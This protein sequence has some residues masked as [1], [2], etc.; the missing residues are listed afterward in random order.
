MSA[1]PKKRTVAQLRLLEKTINEIE[2]EHGNPP[3][4]NRTLADAIDVGQVDLFGGSEQYDALQRALAVLRFTHTSLTR[5]ERDGVSLNETELHGASIM[6]DLAT[7]ALE[8]LGE[9]ALD[10]L[11]KVPLSALPAAEPEHAAAEE[12]QA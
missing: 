3:A 4:D 9:A 12:G 7:D 6:L 10:V 8:A 5:G 2:A 1:K 11:G